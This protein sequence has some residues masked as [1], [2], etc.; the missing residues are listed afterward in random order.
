MDQNNGQKYNLGKIVMRNKL[1]KTI[2]IREYMFNGHKQ[3]KGA[4]DGLG[5]IDR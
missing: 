3:R 2:K 4:N 5:G 1:I